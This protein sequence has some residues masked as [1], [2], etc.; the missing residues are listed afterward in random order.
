MKQKIITLKRDP[1][2]RNICAGGVITVEAAFLYP[3]LILL[4]MLMITLL[5][6]RHNTVWY[7]CAALESAVSGG[8]HAASDAFSELSDRVSRQPFP[9]STPDISIRETG[10]V[11]FVS[12]AGSALPAF[13]ELFPLHVSASVRGV[14]PLEFLQ[15]KW[16][17]ASE[18]KRRE[19]NL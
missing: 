17:E 6:Y 9:G 18:E 2:H 1:R 16:I 3:L 15:R 10:N 19:M 8:A 11:T 13:S 14:R 5:F 12:L 4:T 7:T